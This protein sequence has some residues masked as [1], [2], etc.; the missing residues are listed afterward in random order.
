MKK[1]LYPGLSISVFLLL[2][3]LACRKTIDPTKTGQ[4]QN[5]TTVDSTGHADS[6]HATV[7]TVNVPYPITPLLGCNYSPDYGDS[8]VFPQP[9]NG[10]DY[11]IFPVNNQG[12]DGTYL[13]WPGGLVLNAQTGAIDLTKSE[14]GARYDIGFVKVGTTDTC[15]SQLIIAGAAYMDSVYVLSQNEIYADPYFNANP[16]APSVCSGSSGGPG[17]QFDYNNAAKNQGVVIDNHT[18]IIDLQN[19]M[20]NSLFGLLPI[21]GTTVNTTIYYKLD[22]NSNYA[23]QKI[24]LK[25]MFYN[26]KSNI[27]PS[28]L[29]TITNNLLNTLQDLLLGRSSSSPR[30]PL[31][32]ITRNN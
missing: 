32:I 19:T 14:T 28:I 24:G 17:C 18:G 6:A 31:I 23:P 15:L 4:N 8:I 25:L 21:D 9:A 29:G 30:P 11:V 7:G 13:S 3:V 12:V 27:P 22:D 16:D 1:N 10:Q 5:K 2:S 26:K 20:K